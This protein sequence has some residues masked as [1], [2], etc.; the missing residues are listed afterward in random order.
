MW[1]NKY[2][3]LEYN[4]KA[5]QGFIELYMKEKL[6]LIGHLCISASQ[7]VIHS[8]HKPN[9]NAGLIALLAANRAELVPHRF[10][11]ADNCCVCM[12]N[13]HCVSQH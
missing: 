13:T 1:W 8:E 6:V 12:C 2:L 7:T 11:I 4:F 5:N 3:Y 10:F 9:L